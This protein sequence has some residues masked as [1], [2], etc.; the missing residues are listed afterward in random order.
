MERCETVM[1]AL[2]IG[3]ILCALIALSSGAEPMLGEVT[4]SMDG[5]VQA[6]GIAPAS[7][8]SPRPLLVVLHHWSVSLERFDSTD[9]I[10]A[11]AKVDWHLLL[12]DFRGANNR[13][14]ACGSMLARQDILDAVDYALERYPVD[15]SRIYLAGVSGGGHMA[16]VMAAHAPERWAAVSAWAGISDLAAWHAETKTAN[17]KYF[18]DI[19][20]VVGG[21]PGAS[22]E[23]DAE[24]TLRSPVHHLAKVKDL[25]V[26]IATG[27]HDGHMGSVPIHHSIDAFNAIAE[28]RGDARVDTETITMLSE[29]DYAEAPAFIDETYG[30]GIHLRREA[31]DSRITIFE[32]GHEGIPGAAIA[33]LAQHSREED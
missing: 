9:W 8:E 16:M 10:D 18:R 11:A 27:I 29:Q 14:E 33:W 4:S 30:R 26:D 13:P 24:L 12:P 5:A 32:G 1:C 28:A 17:L 15:E 19:E 25:P 20:S 6:L 22:A 2:R 31:G 7:T 3:A 23:I 21:P